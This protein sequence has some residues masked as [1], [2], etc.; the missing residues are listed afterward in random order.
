MENNS[1]KTVFN[2]RGFISILSAFAF[3]TLPFTGLFMHKA[4][5]TSDAFGIHLWMGAH[6]IFAVL[7]LITAVLHIKYNWQTLISHIK[8]GALKLT[9]LSRET[10]AALSIFLIITLLTAGHAYFG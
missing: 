3:L 5:E 10:L 6:N 1:V 2:K 4:R 9:G 7:F 8:K